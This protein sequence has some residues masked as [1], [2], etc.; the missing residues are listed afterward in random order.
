VKILGLKDKAIKS[1]ATGRVSLASNVA[2]TSADRLSYGHY[3]T[4][5]ELGWLKDLD[6]LLQKN[7]ELKS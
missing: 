4:H 1:P 6:C 2:T 5:K 7:L 3:L